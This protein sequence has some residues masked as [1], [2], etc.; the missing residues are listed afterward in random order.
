[1]TRILVIEDEAPILENIAETLEIEGYEVFTAPNGEAGVQIALREHPN[2]ILCDILM[3]GMDGYGVLAEVRSQRT[4]ANT[5]FIFLTALATRG[6]QRKGMD[7]GADDYLSKPFTPSELLRAINS[8]LEKHAI[9]EQEKQ[10]ELNDLRSRI[11]YALPHEFRTPL[12]GLIGCVDLIMMDVDHIDR[13]DLRAMAEVMY[14]STV[15]L[16]HLIE[17]YLLYS[18]LEVYRNDPR[19]LDITGKETLDYPDMVIHES[20]LQIAQD[21]GRDG[22]LRLSL[23]PAQVAIAHDNF[24]KIVQEVIDNAFKFS[25]TGTDVTVVSEIRDDKLYAVTIC[26]EGRGMSDEDIQGVGAYMQFD[27][28]LYEQQGVGLGL[29]IAKRLTELHGGCMKIDSKIGKGTTICIEL[30]LA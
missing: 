20:A 9:G 18:Q 25:T 29:V 2:L 28:L 13:E 16:S 23:E 12:T 1:M 21:E 14:R 30:P 8:R 15:R 26:D 17:N 4:I 24:R 11:V 3:P 10:D 27:R 5:P 19:G 6:A 7:S 22:D